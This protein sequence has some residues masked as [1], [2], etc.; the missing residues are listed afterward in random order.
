MAY[1]WRVQKAAP[2]HNHINHLHP[3]IRKVATDLKNIASAINYSSNWRI[4][5]Q[6]PTTEAEKYSKQTRFHTMSS[7]LAWHNETKG[8]KTLTHSMIL[9]YP[10]PPKCYHRPDRLLS[11]TQKDRRIPGTQQASDIWNRFS[12]NIPNFST[13]NFPGMKR[14]YT[15]GNFT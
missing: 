10:L 8:S 1:F 2:W 13:W 11:P 12:L 5:F 7:N 15:L 6:Q 14:N 3:H 4:S 9:W